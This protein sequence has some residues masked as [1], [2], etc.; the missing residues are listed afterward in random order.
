M[1]IDNS[2][3][4]VPEFGY[5]DGMTFDTK[6]NIWVAHFLSKKVMCHDPKTGTKIRKIRER[7]RER[8]RERD[9]LLSYFFA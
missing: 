9:N 2:G 4:S 8:E 6:G 7:E 1:V 3:K 5:P